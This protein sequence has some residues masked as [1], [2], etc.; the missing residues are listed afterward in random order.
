M[1]G[2]GQNLFEALETGLGDFRSAAQGEP[3]R[4][5]R[6]LG[7]ARGPLAHGVRTSLAGIYQALV[8]LERLMV[9]VESQLVQAD[10]GLAAVEVF[11]AGLKS[12]ASGEGF[13]DLADFMGLPKAPF[14]ELT[15]VLGQAG[16]A[17]DRVLEFADLLP[18][19]EGVAAIRYELE[20]LLGTSRKP[21]VYLMLLVEIQ[22]PLP[23]LPPPPDREAA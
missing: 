2:L 1:P 13:A 20:R 4:K 5:L 7:E 14:E 12:L 10:A 23:K 21:G 17:A 15:L 11:A 9:L 6:A 16:T 8:G 18:S 19:P 3:G 22:V